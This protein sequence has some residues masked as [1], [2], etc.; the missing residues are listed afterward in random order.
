MKHTSARSLVT[1]VTASVF[2][3]IIATS[4][5]ACTAK[6]PEIFKQG[7]GTNLDTV[8]AWTD[9]IIPLSTGDYIAGHLVS[10][11]NAQDR[12]GVSE[13]VKGMNHF[14][15]VQ[16]NVA[17]S[18][19]AKLLG[20][21]PFRGRPNTTGVYSVKV[22]LTGNYLKFYKVG[23]AEDLPFD[24][25]SYVE[26][27]LADGRIAI[28]MLG[29]KIK[30][31]FR[32]E[33]ET[34]ADD[35]A[36]H[37]LTEIAEL[38]PSK[39]THVRIDWTSRELF[40]AVSTTDLMPANFF[41]SQDKDNHA[42]TPY[43]WYYAET[44]MEKSLS[45][46]ETQVGESATR[47]ENSQMVP[48]SKVVFIPN[49][50]QLR[51]VNVARDERLNKDK[52]KSSEDLN[53]VAALSIPV[54]WTDFRTK[55]DGVNLSL[56]GETV[57]NRKWDQ[58]NFF[59]M[60]IPSLRSAAI[61]SGTTSLL[62]LEVDQNY[63]SFTVLN[64]IGNQGRKIHYS[65]LRADQGRVAYQPRR[66]FKTDQGLFGYFTSVKPFISNWE[67]YTE[68]DTNKRINISRMNPDA[69][70][71][72]FH[73]SQGSPDWLE[74][75]VIRAVAAWDK[76]FE[77]AL[78]ST[79]KSLKI[80]FSKDRVQLGDL[81]YN[82]IHL[83]DT[84]S[85]DGL[86]GFGPSVADPE[87][88]EIIA[89]TTNVYVNSTKAIAANTVRQYIIDRLE[90]RLSG[91]KDTD[92][93]GIASGVTAL[94]TDTIYETPTAARFRESVQSLNDKKINKKSD[95]EVFAQYS[96]ADVQ[97]DM[98]K[99]AGNQCHF[100]E[101][102]VMNASDS[103]IQK[104]CPEAEVLIAND[105]KLDLISRG[106]AQNWEKVWT[107]TKSLLVDGKN[108]DG[109]VQYSCATK[110]TRGKLLST[111]I[112]EI[113]HN[114]GLR[115]NFY[116]SYDKQNF[117]K[118]TTIFGE[119]IT[120]HSSSIM[121]YTDWAEDRMTEAGPYDIAAIRFGYGAQVEAKDGTM[122]A[123]DATKS[124]DS[125]TLKPYL[126][127]TDEVAYTGLSAFCKTDDAGTNPM[128]V[129]QFYIEKY[130]RTEALRKF[131]RAKPFSS[132]PELVAMSNLSLIFLPLK[133]IYD[134]WRYQLG[135]YVRKSARYLSDFDKNSYQTEVLDAMSK[136]PQYGPIYAQYHDAAEKIYAFFKDVAFG[137]NEYC[138]I[139]DRGEKRA[140]ELERLRDLL[141]E[142][143]RGAVAIRTCAD[144]AAASELATVLSAKAPT[145]L[146]EVGYPINSYRFEKAQ[147]YED[148]DRVD[149]VGNQATRTYAGVLI[150]RRL[151]SIRNIINQFAP[152]MTDEPTHLDDFSKTLESRI[153]DGVDLSQYGIKEMAIQPLFSQE[154][155]L[156]Y[157][158]AANFYKGLQTPSDSIGGTNQVV[159]ND[160]RSPFSVNAPRQG[161]DLSKSP[162]V[163]ILNHRPYF[164][165]YSE[166]N[167]FTINLINRYNTVDN[168]VT[169]TAENMYTQIGGYTPPAE[170]L[171]LMTIKSF[172]PMVTLLKTV[173]T[174]FPDYGKCVISK[175]PTLIQL[176]QLIPLLIKDY[177]AAA[178]QGTDGANKFMQ[179]GLADYMKSKLEGKE[180]LFTQENLKDLSSTMET[181][182]KDDLAGDA[183][184]K[185][186]RNRKDYESQ[187][188]L[189]L[190]VLS[191]YAD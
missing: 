25:Q 122:L 121:E 5:T 94:D 55:A 62:D 36:S 173:N 187:K 79:G 33:A 108:T 182:L 140:I 41:F 170:K 171:P 120:A 3:V 166:E 126:F 72:V 177:Q 175:T 190:D 34:T 19:F 45:D 155:S 97:K 23:K 37:H 185:V 158:I 139:S 81:R 21:P 47:V 176:T 147:S 179:L 107:D 164:A 156:V 141:S 56:E 28:P 26:E 11:S 92:N 88:G 180:V 54:E 131:R 157:N 77:T 118:M 119:E 116:G 85:E 20:N 133:D 134:E 29:Y 130:K 153:V 74:D 22:K 137:P 58:R 103:E 123:V 105:S 132:D 10:T 89:A 114:F 149:V 35:L 91:A 163:L 52:S 135:E 98:K 49:E 90:K 93:K 154:A 111:L 31:Y 138:L 128:E 186:A 6:R 142:A 151:P 48:A 12:V 67:Y 57:V 65:F 129:T 136:D 63:F 152:N 167:T 61:A 71:I 84:L 146:A 168:L 16:I 39:A 18:S 80:S 70:E 53:S 15:L 110:I 9:K 78:K 32:I 8:A 150:N 42:F 101:Q 112:H 2:A 106:S 160:K 51:I 189:I 169:L 181:C 172:V 66:S 46:T 60:D 96:M 178:A 144:A 76:T 188:S 27:T 174:T 113:G 125:K 102:A 87:T 115:H 59:Q 1:A 40:K 109:S 14:D 161:E 13:K 69:K 184:R 104:Y 75:I 7:Q 86:L 165:A 148:Y 43:Q 127:C 30:G 82:V 4:F 100:A 159:T 124:L 95:A 50:N 117:K 162:A 38:D 83:V 143:T 73:L 24:E 99:L 145:V 191:A 64:M 44:I 183:L 68:E 17:D